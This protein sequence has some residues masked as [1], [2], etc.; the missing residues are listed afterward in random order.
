M[1]NSE[2][3]NVRGQNLVASSVWVGAQEF[4][5]VAVPS[6][7]ADSGNSDSHV[8]QQP[9]EIAPGL[10]IKEKKSGQEYKVLSKPSGYSRE[11]EI[12]DIHHMRLSF[13]IPEDE[14]RQKFWI[15]SMRSA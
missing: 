4:L 8:P 12:Q 15:L 7:R 10:I 11:I 3:V 5:I 13:S 14:L 9:M 1:S 6:D 2:F